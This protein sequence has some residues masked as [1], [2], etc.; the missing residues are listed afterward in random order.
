ME[1][2]ESFEP[3]E[4]KEDYGYNYIM[5]ISFVLFAQ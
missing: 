4:K 2:E 5:R 1:R 3:R